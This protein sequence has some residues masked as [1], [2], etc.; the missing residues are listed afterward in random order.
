MF[1]VVKVQPNLVRGAVVAFDP[2]QGVFTHSS[3][4]ATPLGVLS[5]DAQEAQSFNVETQTYEPLGYYVAPVSFAGVA[6][7][8][9]SR[10]IPD[11]GGELMVE[12]GQVYVDNDANGAGIV[13]PLPHDQESRKAGSLVMVHIR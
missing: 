5:E 11:E 1:S 8:R 3:S 7:A 6:F 13:C 4:L 10:D 2:L 12:N 9:C